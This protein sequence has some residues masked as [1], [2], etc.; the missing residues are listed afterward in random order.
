MS[1][2]FRSPT[3]LTLAV[4]LPLLV[5]AALSWWGTRAQ[6]LAAWASAREEVNRGGDQVA[7]N[8]AKQMNE[9]LMP[10]QIFPDPPRPGVA[11]QADQALDGKDL[12]A[13]RALRDDP[14][15]GLSPA[16]LPRRVLA[17]FRVMDSG[18]DD[19]DAKQL[20]ELALADAPSVLSG[21]VI[22][23]Y[24]GEVNQNVWREEEWAREAFRKQPNLTKAGAWGLTPEVA[25]LCR[26]EPVLRF[27]TKESLE[28]ELKKARAA[29]PVWAGLRL[30]A[31]GQRYGDATGEVIKSWPMAFGED[32]RLEIVAMKPELIDAD[33]RRQ[34]SW[35]MLVLATSM[36]VC[37]LAL[38][39]LHHSLR[40]ERQLSD[41]KSQFVA[42]VSHEL[43]APVASIRLMAEGLEAGKVEGEMVGDFHR[44]IARESAR[45]STMVTN[46]LDHSRIE[47]GQKVW[48]KQACDLR[49][50]TEESMRVMEPLA[51][52][53]GIVLEA[54]LAEIEA[55]V[56]AGAMQQAL[57]NLLDN[58]I[59]FSPPQGHVLVKLGSIENVVTLSLADAGPGVAEAEKAMIFERFYRS[60]NEL[61]RE[62]Q[63]TGIGLSLVKSI[64][65][66]HGGTASVETPPQGGSIFLIK[67]PHVL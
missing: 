58:A 16:G 63:G 57:V 6:V 65:E 1:R 51:Q 31:G 25:W 53:K 64:V 15:A 47:Q 36:V 40:R 56:D 2:L 11:S 9:L 26:D 27:L 3:W 66:A 4:L 29:L 60:G 35:A 13:L 48:R 23:K 62:T 21:L 61:R 7:Q 55:L 24:G 14:T 43:R 33:A 19:N 38:A 52:E 5:L 8:L 45:L 32:A 30:L 39:M 54:D 44:L 59:K 67:F 37:G 10:A 49:A 50:L 17:G 34:G 12:T 46:V 22:E 18:G 41:M 28:Q 42:S 20:I